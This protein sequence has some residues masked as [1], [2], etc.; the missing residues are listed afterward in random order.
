MLSGFDARLRDD[1]P[2]MSA[3]R[4]PGVDLPDSVGALAGIADDEALLE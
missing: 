3:L 2:R 1:E 4:E